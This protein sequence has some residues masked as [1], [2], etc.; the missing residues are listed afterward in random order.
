[1]DL[2][3]FDFKE[4]ARRNIEENLEKVRMERIKRQQEKAET[5]LKQSGIGRR[6]KKRNFNNFLVND[7][8]KE[9]YDAAKNFVE[10]F[11]ETLGLMLIGPVGT[12]K[13]HLAAA[14]TNSLTQKLYTVLFGNSTDI[15]YR[16]RKTY[17]T[18]E[19][20]LD[21]I[22]ALTSVD[23]LVID[24]LGKE[25]TS[26]YTST[27]IYQIINRLYEEEK[28]VII[29]TNYVSGPLIEHLGEKGEEI[30]SRIQEMCI[31]VMIEGEDWR[32]KSGR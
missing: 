6:F 20:E 2:S 5:L 8:N 17:S 10:S 7:N 21:L 22:D 4:L 18:D 9:A 23:L 28:P 11:P 12:G 30:F 14:I 26:E 25:K 29:T 16:F 27:L 32:M 13:T 31:P 24:D 19:S 3:D 1:M 15:I